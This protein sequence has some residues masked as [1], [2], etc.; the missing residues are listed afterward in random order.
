MLE[1]IKRFYYKKIYPRI[2]KRPVLTNKI[3]KGHFVE[4]GKHTYGLPEIFFPLSG[5]KLWI[6]SF[7]SIGQNVIIFLGGNHR[8]DW[9]ST[10]PFRRF[11]NIFSQALNI[12]GETSGNGDVV[13][14]NDVWIGYGAT[15][16]SG[17]VIGDGAV[18]AAHSVVTKNVAPYT[19]VGG[20]PA[21][22]I[23]QRFDEG[24][25]N[26]LLQIEWWKWDDNK[27]NDNT[28]LLND[29]KITSFLE[30]HKIN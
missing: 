28:R 10:Y 5:K 26:Q 8:M 22:I 30:K 15:I 23:R 21:K 29:D 17:V 14:G 11:N 7:C 2:Y 18:I 4:V 24:V 27:I 9:V 25:I 1:S 6:G 13:I 3:L 20:N 12:T 19:V 16:L